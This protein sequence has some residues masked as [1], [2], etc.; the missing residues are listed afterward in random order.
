MGLYKRGDL[1]WCQ[2]YIKGVRQ[3]HPTGTNNRREAGQIFQQ[4]KRRANARR[5][6]VV[7]DQHIPTINEIAGLF[8]GKTGN[9]A[10]HRERLTF[11]LPFFGKHRADAVSKAMVEEYRVARSQKVK[12]ATCNR[13][14][15]VL[16]RILYW[17]LDEHLI[18]F[19]PLRRSKMPR[20]PKLHRRVL[21]VEDERKLLRGAPRHLRFGI[22]VAGDTGMRR[23]EVLGQLIEHLDP[24]RLLLEVSKSKTAGGVG[25]EIPWTR[26]LRPILRNVRGD[27]RLVT[28]RDEPIKIL[29]T[30]W[31]TAVQKAGIR[32]L[33]FHDLR[34][35]FNT[36][37]MEA[38]VAQDVRKAL[39]GHSDGDI[40]ATYTHVEL[41][42][43]R[44]AIQQLNSWY[45]R[46]RLNL[47]AQHQRKYKE[48]Q[49]HGT[50][51]TTHS[52][53]VPRSITETD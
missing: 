44:Q 18:D 15:S 5:H 39:M 11:L 45:A 6:R 14:I 28:F 33:R 2:F 10:Y 12:V 26:R 34:H 49:R 19:N 43:K 37:L 8:L 21:S 30:G 9:N 13:D 25:R 24:T 52:E 23:G 40:N 17:A 1:Y 31:R 35:T 27:G 46:Q 36:R 50:L 16:R 41:P 7:I 4:L 51:G 32:Y 42:M 3:L 22:L 20:E 38:G 48:E 53:G 29:K 47:R